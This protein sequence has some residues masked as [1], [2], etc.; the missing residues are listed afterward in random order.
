M[1]NGLE[2][3]LIGVGMVCIDLVTENGSQVN[4]IFIGIML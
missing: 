3:R 2:G 1:G 4:Y